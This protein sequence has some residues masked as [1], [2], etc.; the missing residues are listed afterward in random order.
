MA[1]AALAGEDQTLAR[2]MLQGRLDSRSDHV[3][4]LDVVAALIDDAKAEI[5]LEIPELPQVHQ[6][7]AQS[8]VL[9]QH[10]VD[11][12]FAKRG[13]EIGVFG[14]VDALAPRIAAANV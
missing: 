14:E 10:L 8:A 13:R 6:I 11:L 5:A 4:R 9:E 7:V 1:E 3:D 12:H 2:K